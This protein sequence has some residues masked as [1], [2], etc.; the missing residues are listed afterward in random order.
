[1]TPSP[2]LPVTRRFFN[3]T[4]IRPEDIREVAY[5]ASAQHALV[6]WAGRNQRSPRSSP[7][8]SNVIVLGLQASGPRN[9]LQRAPD[10]A[11]SAILSFRC[12]EG[13]GLENFAFWC[14]LREKRSGEEFPR[15]SPARIPSAANERIALSGAH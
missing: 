10:R 6:E 4:Y 8:R 12:A 2:Y 5:M 9:H 1:M 7:A 11:D 14:A 15:S 3:P 13:E